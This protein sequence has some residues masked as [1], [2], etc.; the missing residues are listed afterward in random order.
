MTEGGTFS[1][2][3]RRIS[4]RSWL[5]LAGGI[6][7]VALLYVPDLKKRIPASPAPLQG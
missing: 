1:A 3:V 6:I 7:V 2:S 5:L 4:L